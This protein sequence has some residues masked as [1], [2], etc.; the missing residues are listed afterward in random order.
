MNIRIEISPLATQSISGVGHYTKRLTEALDSE[1]STALTAT[2]F[3]FLNRQKTPDVTLKQNPIKNPFIPLR[4]Y[5]KLQSFNVR[6]PF[7]LFLPKADL[8]VFPNFVTWPT[9]RS[10]RSATVV[11]DLTY[12]YFPEVVEDKNLAHLRRVVPRTLKEA[13]FII[14]VSEAVKAEIVKEFSYDPSRCIV[15]PVPAEPEYFRENT[16]EIHKKYSIPTEKFIFFI[17]NME[18]RKN[19]KTLIEAYHL[20]PDDIK[21]EYSLVL[22]GGKGWKSEST[23]KA[24]A[25]AQATGDKVI[26]VGYIDQ[27]DSPA[28][29]QKASL[30]VMPSIYE[31]FGMPVV[32]AM[33]GNTP[34]VASDIPVLREAGGD[35]ALYADPADPTSFRDAIMRVLTTPTLAQEMREKG[36]RQA[37]SFSWKENAERIVSYA[38]SL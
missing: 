3:N 4:V 18:P 13:D 24:I 9:V 5:A 31:G 6:I 26:H 36:A 17:G 2:Y 23:Q 37:R 20:L 7:D 11:H 12:L 15:T 10:K 14:T 34:V 38:K 35:A 32:E 25:D 29:F 19:Q 33:A 22:A 21:N 8:T 1:P 27:A 30:Y 28:F 16:N